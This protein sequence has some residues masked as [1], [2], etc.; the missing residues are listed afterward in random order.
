MQKSEMAKKDNEKILSVF[1][2]GFHQLFTLI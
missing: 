1:A 2:H